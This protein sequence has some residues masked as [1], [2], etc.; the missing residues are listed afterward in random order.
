MLVPKISETTLDITLKGRRVAFHV[1]G[2]L[3]T[4]KYS[5]SPGERVCFTNNECT[6]VDADYSGKPEAVVDPFLPDATTPGTLF[7][8][9]PW[10]GLT[11][12]L[13][14]HFDVTIDLQKVPQFT[15]PEPI[16]EYV[17]NTEDEYLDDDGCKGCYD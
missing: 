6:E 3:V 2:I 12:N 1:P 13:T 7:W 14:H 15:P 11:G 9:F 17:E 4:S 16:K 8:V 10:P 5:M